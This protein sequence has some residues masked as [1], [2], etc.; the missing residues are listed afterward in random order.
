MR[1]HGDSLVPGAY[2]AMWSIS[3]EDFERRIVNKFLSLQKG[4]REAGILNAKNKRIIVQRAADVGDSDND[5][6]PPVQKSKA[7]EK[8]NKT[9][10][11]TSRANGVSVCIFFESMNLNWSCAR[12]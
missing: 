7:A 12:N 4:L 10:M 2:S 6:I 8:K 3:E 9:G 5:G 1:R 11:I